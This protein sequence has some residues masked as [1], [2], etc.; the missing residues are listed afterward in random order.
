MWNNV[1]RGGKP[2]PVGELAA[3][4]GQQPAHELASSAA[5][6]SV[7]FFIGNCFSN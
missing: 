5:G 2:S 4:L 7:C 6:T 3:A 1:D